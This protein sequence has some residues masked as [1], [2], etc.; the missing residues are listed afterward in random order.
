M[1]YRIIF[2]LVFAVHL[3]SGQNNIH[4]IDSLLNSLHA[5]GRINGNVL[6]ADKGNIIYNKSFGVAN[7]S[8]RQ[9][10]NEN[11]VFD[12]C[13]VSKQFTAMGIMLLKERGKLKLDDPISKYIPELSFYKGITIRHLLHHTGGLPDYMEILEKSFDKTQIATN[14]DIVAL[15]VKEKP[16]VMFAPNSAWEY[17]NTGYALLAVIIESASGKKYDEF[18][19]Q[20]IFNPLKMNSTFVYNRRYSPRDIKNYALGYVYSDSLNKL[21]LPDDLEEYSYVKLLDGV[22]GDGAVNSTVTD[23]LKWDNALYTDK[24]ISAEGIDEMFTPVSLDDGSTFDYGFGWQLDSGKV[25]GKRVLHTGGWP[26]YNTYFDR[27]LDNGKTI[28]ILQNHHDVEM[29]YKPI[30]YLLYGLPVPAPPNRTEITLS[31]EQLNKVLGVYEIKEGMEF[32]ISLKAGAPYAQMSNQPALRIYPE[33]GTSFFLKEF[34]AVIQ[35]VTGENGKV[36]K[37]IV[38]QGEHRTEANKI[39]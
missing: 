7:E 4:H 22:V 25:F 11:S 14:K 1:K 27:H 9:E 33:S 20:N 6:I 28:I 23:L 12:L 3:L 34:D 24:L 36:N 18:L 10:L 15:F 37:L 16:A 13:S 19:A 8:T 17:S 38:V 21:V 31:E 26:G 5:K 2:V 39:R 29:V 32:T 30:R 35:F